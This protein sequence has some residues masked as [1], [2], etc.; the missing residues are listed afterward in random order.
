MYYAAEDNKTEV[1]QDTMIRWN[2]YS[3][4]TK[5]YSYSD[6]YHWSIKANKKAIKLAEILMSF[7]S[8][9]VQLIQGSSAQT[10]FT[11][12]S[13]TNNTNAITASS[14]GALVVGGFKCGNYNG[15]LA[16]NVTLPHD[17]FSATA[18]FNFGTQYTKAIVYK[19]GVPTVQKINGGA[20][21]LNIASGDGLFIVPIEG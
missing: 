3:D 21:T 1:L 18:T 4:W 16:S 17:N 5:G 15:Y 7:D 11:G 10:D 13:D 6:L 9:G 20:L 19:D 14:T 8:V 12:A 2:D